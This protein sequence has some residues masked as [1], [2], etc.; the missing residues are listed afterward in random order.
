MG[1]PGGTVVKN[2][3]ANAGGRHRRHRFDPWVRKILCRRKW[4]PTPVF[5]PEKFQGQRILVGFNPWVCRV[6]H[7]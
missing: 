6:G 7:N 2:P 4:Q 1:F 5:L 3:P